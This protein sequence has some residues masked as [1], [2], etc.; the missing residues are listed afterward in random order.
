MDHLRSDVNLRTVG[1]KDPLM[2]FKHDAFLFFDDFGK[3]LRNEAAHD[4]FRFEIIMRPL[5][6][7]QDILSG[8][9]LET[10]RSFMPEAG[11]PP[12]V[13]TNQA[14]VNAMAEEPISEKQQPIFVGA[15]IGRNDNCP[16]GSGKKYKKC[17]G[18]NAEDN[19]SV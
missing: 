11:Q 5:P 18:I 2:E 10:A 9:Q 1:Q 13:T 4:L 16:C 19:S 6:S 14:E 8:L 17:C 3:T 15:K 12:Q 7:L